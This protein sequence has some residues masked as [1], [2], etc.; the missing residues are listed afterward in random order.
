MHTL[1]FVEM[2]NLY[3][4]EGRKHGIDYALGQN[5]NIARWPHITASREQYLDR[6]R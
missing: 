2:A 3:V 6:L 1:S 4:E 5:Q